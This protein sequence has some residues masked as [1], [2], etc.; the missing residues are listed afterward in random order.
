MG[1]CEPPSGYLQKHI[2]MKANAAVTLWPK[3]FPATMHATCE[4]SQDLP[5]RIEWEAFMP[6]PTAMRTRR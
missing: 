5:G 3:R 2:R 6:Y 4:P 1:L